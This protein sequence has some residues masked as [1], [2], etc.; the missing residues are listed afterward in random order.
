MDFYNCT[1][2]VA[3]GADTVLK[4]DTATSQLNINYYLEKSMLKN[5]PSNAVVI[6]FS[7]KPANY[8]TTKNFYRQVQALNFAKQN[9][10]K[11]T[12]VID[13]EAEQPEEDKTE[14][15]Y[16]SINL[17]EGGKSL[18][19]ID[20]IASYMVSVLNYGTEAAQSV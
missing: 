15:N 19:N 14:K 8:R 5:Y 10:D 7:S 18:N 17:E 20:T 16:L 3:I 11:I 4:F 9:Q 2:E 12:R 1:R 6:S 13:F